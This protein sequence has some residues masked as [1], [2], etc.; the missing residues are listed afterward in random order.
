MF[1][2]QLCQRE[3]ENNWILTSCQPHRVHSGRSNSI[4]NQYTLYNFSLMQNYTKV[5]S[6]N[7][8]KAQM[9][10]TGNPRKV[11]FPN[12]TIGKLIAL[13]PEPINPSTHTHT[14][15]HTRTRTQTSF[16][17]KKSTGNFRNSVH[18]A[19]LV[20]LFLFL[21]FLSLPKSTL[22]LRKYHM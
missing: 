19:T 13:E 12:Q 14:H 15:T 10:K 11:S 17:K 2:Y 4:I 7:S 20:M 9:Y 5:T 8:V 3:R 18:G 1:T 6:T 16:V 21:V 22:I